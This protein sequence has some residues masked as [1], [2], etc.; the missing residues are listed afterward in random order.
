MNW[1]NLTSSSNTEGSNTSDESGIWSHPSK[2]ASVPISTPVITEAKSEPFMSETER[3]REW[4]WWWKGLQSPGERNE[5]KGCYNYSDVYNTI[6]FGIGWIDQTMCCH[7]WR[8]A[9]AFRQCLNK[10]STFWCPS[11]SRSLGL[12]FGKHWTKKRE[13]FNKAC[14]NYKSPIIHVSTVSNNL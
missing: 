12:A 3:T 13:A 2:S 8:R 14:G 5:R 4:I 11:L 10:I 9:L 6:A 7:N 1:A